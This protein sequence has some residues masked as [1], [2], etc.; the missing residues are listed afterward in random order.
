[1]RLN[2]FN[3]GISVKEGSVDLKNY[4]QDKKG[5][6]VL[7]T[8]DKQGKVD[9][10]I[11]M[12]PCIL[13]DG[14]AAF[15]M[16]DKL[17]YANVTENPYAYFLFKEDGPGYSGKRLALKKVKQTDD[18]A[19]VDEIRRKIFNVSINA[20]SGS[21]KMFVVFFEIE[22]ELPLVGTGVS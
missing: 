15:L 13:D 5:L 22:K 4:F 11:Y 21:E 8:S 16:A 6:G 12:S 20:S 7:S 14:T 19:V 9:A 17:S 2:L 18:P 3:S 1:M 10:A